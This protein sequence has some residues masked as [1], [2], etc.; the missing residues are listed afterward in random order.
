M[1]T[2]TATQ[3]NKSPQEIFTAAKEEGTVLIEHDRYNGV[4]AIVWN[5]NYTEEEVLQQMQGRTDLKPE[6]LPKAGNIA[7]DSKGVKWVCFHSWSDGQ[8]VEQEWRGLE[9]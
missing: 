1:K 3:L 8:T 5:P 6:T 4:F 9:D 7:T 2:F